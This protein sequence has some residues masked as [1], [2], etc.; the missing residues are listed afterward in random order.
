MDARSMQS[1]FVICW[2]PG[3]IFFAVTLVKAWM[4]VSTDPRVHNAAGHRAQKD[5]VEHFSSSGY[6]SS[7]PLSQRSMKHAYIYWSKPN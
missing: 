7:Y 4:P 2:I 3:M 1:S 6:Y 5:S